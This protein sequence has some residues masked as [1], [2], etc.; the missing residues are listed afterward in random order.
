MALPDD[1]TGWTW[2]PIPSPWCSEAGGMG[3]ALP[4][5]LC[6]HC[7]LSLWEKLSFA[8]PWQ[9]L[10]WYLFFSIF[11]GLLLWFF[12]PLSQP[13]FPTAPFD[14]AAQSFCFPWPQFLHTSSH[15]SS[16]TGIFSVRLCCFFLCPLFFLHCFGSFHSQIGFCLCLLFCV[17]VGNSFSV[18][19][20]WVVLASQK[21]KILRSDFK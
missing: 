7:C 20:A 2:P 10:L 14:Q 5:W 16:L 11:I 1:P 15:C 8:A 6:C 21:R 3:E 19:A 17:V 4:C 18:L 9:N 13:P 12:C